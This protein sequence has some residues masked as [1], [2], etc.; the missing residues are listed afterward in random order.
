MTESTSGSRGPE[1]PRLN[2]N[3]SAVFRQFLANFGL[4]APSPGVTTQLGHPWPKSWIRPWNHTL[5][6][7]SQKNPEAKSKG[8][9]LTGLLL[10]WQQIHNLF[11]IHLARLS[12]YILF[13]AQK[14]QQLESIFIQGICPFWSDS[15][16]TTSSADFE[17]VLFKSYLKKHVALTQLNPFMWSLQWDLCI[18]KRVMFR[19][20]ES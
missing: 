11:R 9:S 18:V 6:G 13:Q 12:P 8:R 16:V 5:L 3:H 14:L 20:H 1:P 17:I 19:T 4:S 2:K 7:I 10:F 15:Y